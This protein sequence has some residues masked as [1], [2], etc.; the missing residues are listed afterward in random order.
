MAEIAV[1]TTGRRRI[2]FFVPAFTGGIGGAERVISTLLRHLD[3]DRFDCHV[4]LVQGDRAFLEDLP[5]TATAHQLGVSRMRYSLPALIRIIRRLRAQTVLATVPHLNVMLI[6]ARPFLPPGTRLLLREATTPS[7]F[8][9]QDAQHPKLWSWMYRNV[10]PRAD[11]IICLSDAMLEDIAAHFSVPR[12][13]LVRIYNPLDFNRLHKLASEHP[14]PYH[15]P[16]PHLVAAGRLRREKGADLLLEAMPLVLQRFSNARLTIMGEGP[17]EAA[18]RAQAAQ[19]KVLEHVDFLGFEERPWPYLRNATLFV[20]PSRRE[21][22]PNALLEALALGTPAV[23]TSCVGAIRE[24]EKT[25]SQLLV[26]EPESSNALAQGIISALQADFQRI[27]PE[28]AMEQLR[29]FDAKNVAQQYA[30]LF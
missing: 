29:D 7:A 13:K 1:R 14:S 8:I 4:A 10:Y 26:V 6:A 12:E 11:K 15:G 5:S 30:D 21:G 9:R 19:L 18:L 17:E 23:A 25:T 16:G 20:L 28:H 22:M 3:P 2:L 27:S 24:I